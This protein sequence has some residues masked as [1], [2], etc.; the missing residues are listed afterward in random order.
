MIGDMGI[1]IVPYSGSVKYFCRM[2]GFD[3]PRDGE[4]NNRIRSPWKC[5]MQH[6]AELT[7]R[8]YSLNSRLRLFDCT[9]TAAMLYGSA[10]RALT[11]ELEDKI[12]RT[13][14]TR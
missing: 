5:F 1:D 4:I 8:R 9:V 7:D 3:R 6:R 11:R 2:V 10:T 14:G 12:L 13:Q